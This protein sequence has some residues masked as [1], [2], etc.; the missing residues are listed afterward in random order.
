MIGGQPPWRNQLLLGKRITGMPVNWKPGAG[1]HQASPTPGTFSQPS[2]A[3][4]PLW[5]ITPEYQRAL[6]FG[7][8]FW[9]SKSTCTRPNRRA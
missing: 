8:R 5:L 1:G 2:A 7:V 3:G 9:V 4:R 6:S